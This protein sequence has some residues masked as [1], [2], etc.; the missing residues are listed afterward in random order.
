MQR[1]L[2]F[3]Q[4]QAMARQAQAQ[5]QRAAAAVAAG[6]SG[7][8]MGSPGLM[9]GYMDVGGNVN[10]IPDPMNSPWLQ[11]QQQQ[12]QPQQQQR[13]Q[14]NLPMNISQQQQQQ[15]LD[16]ENKIKQERLQQQRLAFM[17]QREALQQQ[18]RQQLLRQT[19]QQ[20]QPIAQPMVQPALQPTVPPANTI[21]VQ[22]ELQ[23]NNLDLYVG[24]DQQYQ[25][26]L[27]MQH[28]RHMALAQAKKHE[29]DIANNERRVRSQNRGILTFG[30][31]Y[32]GYGNGRTT[33][34][35]HGRVMYPGDKKRKRHHNTIR[36]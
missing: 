13:M 3:L 20:Q 7:G 32:D 22:N 27:D 24:R 10:G 1:N 18:Q 19:Q 17:Q 34:S 12:L 23:Q 11:Q 28:K 5:Q 6:G 33:A 29:I 8:N 2:L 4:Q 9:G 35:N 30:K 14:P 36:L 26:T 16:N 31:G 21:V 25:M 15:Q